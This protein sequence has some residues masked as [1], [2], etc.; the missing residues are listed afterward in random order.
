MKRVLVGFFALVA[1]LSLFACTMPSDQSTGGGTASG[2][3]YKKGDTGPAGGIVFYDRGFTKDGWR[4]LEAAPAGK[5]FVA[6]WGPYNVNV[7]GTETKVGSGK[8]NT[9]L[10]VAAL[11]DTENAAQLCASLNFNRHNDWFLPSKDELD[12]MYKNLRLGDFL[13][14]YWSSSQYDYSN[15]NAWAQNFYD[16]NQFFNNKIYS[17]YVRAIRA[18]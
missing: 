5:E 8:Q 4:Y 13:L 17:I 12:L 3:I 14:I 2:R 10:I 11:G 16:G 6:K 9:Q 1:V 18:F 15:D 7:A